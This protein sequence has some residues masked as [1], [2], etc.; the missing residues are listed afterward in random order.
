MPEIYVDSLRETHPTKHWPYL[1]ACHLFTTP[2]NL[3]ALHAFAAR[4]RLKHS[5]F[6]TQ[7]TLPHYDLTEAK[8]DQA[9]AMGAVEIDWERYKQIFDAWHA[10]HRK[11]R[12][13]RR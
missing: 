8:R 12:R 2:G 13:R 10:R 7:G 3:G 9:L 11:P 1:R 6:Q 5:Y 4:M